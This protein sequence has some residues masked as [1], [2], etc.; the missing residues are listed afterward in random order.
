MEIKLNDIKFPF[1]KENGYQIISENNQNF[2][3]KG[4][5]YILKLRERDADDEFIFTTISENT[6]I[7]S[8]DLKENINFYYKD[9]IVLNNQYYMLNN[10]YILSESNKNEPYSLLKCEYDERKRESY[11]DS[12]YFTFES[13]LRDN[14]MIYIGNPRQNEKS[15]YYFNTEK[16]ALIYN[17]IKD[18][19]LN[20]NYNGSFISLSSSNFDMSHIKEIKINNNPI[21]AK[22][23]SSINNNLITYSFPKNDSFKSYL[24]ELIRIDH[25]LDLSKTIKIK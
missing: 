1:D 12:I 10:I 23:F 9:N 8:F 22:S 3:Y 13:K 16:I 2:N 19:D 24:N 4:N 7:T 5:K 17:S 18:S 21:N 11:C 6:Y 15:S 14:F 20:I 25:S